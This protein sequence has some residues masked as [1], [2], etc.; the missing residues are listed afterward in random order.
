MDSGPF[1]CARRKLK[2]YLEQGCEV[3]NENTQEGMEMLVKTGILMKA[4][5]VVLADFYCSHGLPFAD[6]VLDA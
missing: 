4:L 1:D 5:G 6:G 2:K 3:F